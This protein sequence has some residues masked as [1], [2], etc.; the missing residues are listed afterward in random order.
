MQLFMPLNNANVGTTWAL[1]PFTKGTLCNIPQRTYLG[2]CH[3]TRDIHPHQLATLPA[4]EQ[5]QQS[6]PLA[7]TYSSSHPDH[8]TCA[9]P[10]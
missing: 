9:M 5:H 7:N 6:M 2:H 3:M 10:S 4:M 8:G 1:H